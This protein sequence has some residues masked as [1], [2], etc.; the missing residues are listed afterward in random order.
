MA[1]S[2]PRASM[3]REQIQTGSRASFDTSQPLPRL[4]C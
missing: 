3:R 2:P 1:S 4:L